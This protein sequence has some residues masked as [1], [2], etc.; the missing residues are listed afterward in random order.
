MNIFALLFIGKIQTFLVTDSHG[1]QATYNSPKR[2]RLRSKG[3]FSI[4]ATHF[5]LKCVI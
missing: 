2:E 1:D 3:R 5:K 4:V